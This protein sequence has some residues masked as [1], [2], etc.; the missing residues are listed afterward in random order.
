MWDISICVCDKFFVVGYVCAIFR[1]VC[2][3]FRYVCAIFSLFVCN[4]LVIRVQYFDMY[5]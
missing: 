4:N 2:A 1:Y 5:V 3:I